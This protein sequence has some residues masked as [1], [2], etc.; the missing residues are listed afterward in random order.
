MERLGT[1][2][3]AACV[4]FMLRTASLFGLTYRD[5]NA[6]LFFVIWPAVTAILVVVVTAQRVAL[7]RRR[8]ER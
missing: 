2:L 4:D 8:R 6:A 7:W 3:Y 5:T 1:A